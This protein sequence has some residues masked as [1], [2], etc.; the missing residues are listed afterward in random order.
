[1]DAFHS[2]AERHA[3][4]KGK[5]QLVEDIAGPVKQRFSASNTEIS[6]LQLAT[7]SLAYLNHEK[8]P[9]QIWVVPAGQGK[10]KIHAGLT[11][12]FLEHTDYDV[13]VVF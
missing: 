1:M 4:L 12:L 5:Q 8:V 10:S 2:I 11:Y 9:K 13:Y 6:H 3:D 7:S